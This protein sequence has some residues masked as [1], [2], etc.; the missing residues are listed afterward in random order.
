MIGWIAM[1]IEKIKKLLKDNIQKLNEE[2][3][4]YKR[5]EPKVY[6]RKKSWFEG[7]ISGM[8]RAMELIGMLKDSPSSRQRRM[9]P[10][11]WHVP[12]FEQ[13]VICRMKSNGEMVSGYV[14]KKDGVTFVATESGF[15][16]ED[17]GNYEITHWY[18]M[19][20]VKEETK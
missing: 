2:L 12:P 1:N 11:K 7:Q 9:I 17:Y 15:E 13:K 20:E 16:F 6:E 10:V 3:D 18:P 19:P 14:Y 4:A 5:Y 8:R